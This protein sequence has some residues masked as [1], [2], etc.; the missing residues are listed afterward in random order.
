MAAPSSAWQALPDGDRAFQWTQSGG[1]QSLGLLAPTDG[2]SSAFGVSADGAVVAGFSGSNAVIWTN[3]IAQDLGMLPG[4]R[5]AI[6]YAVGADGS[7]IGGYSFFGSSVRATLWSPTLGLVD[8]NT[9]LPTLGIDL[10]GWELQ[11]TRDISLDGTTLVGEGRFNG[12]Y[13]GWAVT[14]PTPGSVAVLGM[15]GLLAARRRR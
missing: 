3:G 4:A 14:I 12:E 15:A 11:Y 13:R 6:A 9:Y 2:W 8:L 5:N 7:L 1:M 10:S